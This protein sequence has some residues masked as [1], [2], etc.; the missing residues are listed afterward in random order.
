MANGRKPSQKTNFKEDR[1]YDSKNGKRSGSRRNTNRTGNKEG[2]EVKS[3]NDPAWYS[4]NAE[5]LRDAASIPFSWPTGTT[6]DGSGKVYQDVVPGLLTMELKPTIG[7][8]MTM[9]SPVNVASNAIYSFV[10][11]ANSGHSNYDAPD[12]MMYLLAMSHIYSFTTWC[13]RLLG[14][15]NMYDQKNRYLPYALVNA[16]HV[17][18]GDLRNNIA[19]FR[20]WLNNFI[21]KVASLAVPATMNV[22]SRLAFLYSNVYIDGP[23]IKDQLYMFIPDIEIGRSP[24]MKFSLDSNQAGQLEWASFTQ[25]GSYLKVS[26]I[27]DYGTMLFN[28]IWDQEDFGIMSGDILKA[29]GDNI[30][31][32][33]PVPVDFS[34]APVC[35]TMVLHQFKNAK[36][37]GRSFDVSKITQSNG[38]ISQLVFV[39]ST[40]T[41][42]AQR[43]A[44]DYALLN[45]TLSSDF[46]SPT[47]EVVIEST[48]L[49]FGYDVI[50]NYVHCGTEL[51]LRCVAWQFSNNG[52]LGYRNLWPYYEY[53]DTSSP[54]LA[55]LRANSQALGYLKAFKYAPEV[56]Y[57]EYNSTGNL[58]SADRIWDIDNYAV[59]NQNDII[60]MHEA[61]LMSLFAV[62]AIAKIS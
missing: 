25:A 18:F 61:A 35:D 7:S 49:M 1:N 36:L 62:P 42:A 43:L 20:Y 15:I 56:F 31:K 22:F 6:L 28:A 40:L 45:K 46:E 37:G 60:K 10:R 29:Y 52:T 5:L 9:N 26:E 57:M 17:D 47:P 11:H 38:I 58:T 44:R 48:R 33:A 59:L 50:S 12:L 39:D 51:P 8:S 23:T 16:N 34:L 53:L 21:T 32:L 4:A 55:Q 13:Q 30:I 27:E 41:T 3:T 14:I 19:N 54:T 2:K 24:W